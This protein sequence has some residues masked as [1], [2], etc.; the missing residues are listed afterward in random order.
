METAAYAAFWTAVVSTAVALGAGLAYALIPQLAVR[1]SVTNVGTIQVPVVVTGPTWLK[2]G[3]Q[4]MTWLSVAVLAVY[5]GLRWGASGLPPASNM[6]E[7]TVA[8]G[9]AMVVGAGLVD[10]RYR[11]WGLSLGLLASAV[12]IFVI[13]EVAF[14]SQI[15]LLPAPHLQ[16]L[17]VKN[18][19][20]LHVGTMLVAFGAFGVAA[21]SAAG[22][23][24]QRSVGRLRWLPSDRI[25]NEI[26]DRSLEIGLPFYTLGLVVGSYWM[27]SLWGRYWDWDAKAAASLATW[28]IFF[29]YI[30][31]RNLRSWRGVKAPL[32]ILAGFAALMF[33][34]FGVNVLMSTPFGLNV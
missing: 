28:F 12:T 4:S 7:Y 9:A 8:F 23:V 25:L 3:S 15:S 18:L 33:S 34:Y 27:N 21:V 20:A 19:L 6:W 13:A 10:W 2:G 29:G 5:L 11:A 30:H 17:Q 16:Y 1:S 14:S 24:A 32:L 31:V 22:L 26:S